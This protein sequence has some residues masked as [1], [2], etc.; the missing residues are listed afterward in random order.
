VSDLGE[1]RE[2][3]TR[4]LVDDPYALDALAEL[5]LLDILAGFPVER[6]LRDLARLS[7]PLAGAVTQ[8]AGQPERLS[9]CEDVY[10]IGEPSP[11]QAATLDGALAFMKSAAAGLE[12]PALLVEFARPP[13]TPTFAHIPGPGFA[14]ICFGSRD[15]GQTFASVVHELAHAW[16]VAG[17][18]YLDEGVARYF[19]L[20]SVEADFTK[21]AED[22]GRASSERLQ[23]R[24][25]LTYA[26]TDDPYFAKLNL[27]SRTLVHDHGA[28]FARW[29][30]D[31]SGAAGLRALCVAVRDAAGSEPAS[32]T[33]ERHLGQ[34]LETIDREIA[35]SSD[36]EAPPAR[37]EGRLEEQYAVDVMRAMMRLDGRA[38]ARYRAEL[39]RRSPLTRTDDPVA[40]ESWARVLIFQLL[41]AMWTGA[42]E[43]ADAAVA[44]GVIERLEKAGRDAATVS[45]LRAM[46]DI[47]QLAF[48]ANELSG[49]ARL[50]SVQT[51]FEEALRLNPDNVES[52]YQSARFTLLTPDEY[53]SDKARAA[54][55]MQR[56]TAHETLGEDVK[57]GVVAAGWQDK[58]SSWSSM[59]SPA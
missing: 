52:Q 5:A 24:T 22:V 9:R 29:V 54:A 50:V 18:R 48:V 12:A 42:V 35:G 4:R 21:L 20:R 51:R 32:Q 31:R 33:V 17:V 23:L 13:N 47:A 45:T 2:T 39:E 41:S 11:Q 8:L 36:G 1:R 6:R 43:E 19:E 38:I 46:L 10:L 56:L 49:V 30:A 14:Y 25:L 3:L 28:L 53:A 57:A 44:E 40:L 15:E 16:F 26:A 55:C 37:K 34:T 58:L 7:R 27:P 59:S